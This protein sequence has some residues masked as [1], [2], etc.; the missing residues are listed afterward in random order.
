MVASYHYLHQKLL[1]VSGTGRDWLQ[2]IHLDWTRINLLHTN[3]D[4][5]INQVLA[6]YPMVFQEDLGDIKGATATLHVD[7]SQQP[8]F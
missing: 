5:C 3:L 2:H 1:I 8:H 6:K 7:S 4:Q